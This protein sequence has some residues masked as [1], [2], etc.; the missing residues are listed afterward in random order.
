MPWP[1]PFLNF[2]EMWFIQRVSLHAP[3]QVAGRKNGLAQS[4]WPPLG[5][6]ER[7][8]L[9]APWEALRSWAF[10]SQPQYQVGSSSSL[11]S[12]PRGCYSHILVARG[13]TK[14]LLHATAFPEGIKK[15]LHAAIAHLPSVCLPVF[16]LCRQTKQ[17]KEIR[18]TA[19][20]QL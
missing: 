12:Q 6:V 3:L 8:V 4:Q 16:R 18:I 14:T 19:H 9:S 1:Q 10:Y 17:I 20:Q 11:L 15:R 13:A 2:H 7:G 5:S